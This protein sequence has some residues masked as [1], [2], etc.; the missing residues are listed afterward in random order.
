MRRLFII[1]DLH[2]GGSPDVRDTDGKITRTGYRICNAHRELVDFI[3]WAGTQ[4]NGPP[5]DL[6]LVINGDLVDFLADDDRDGPDLRACIWTENEDQAI[7]K[8][9]RIVERSW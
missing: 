4:G 2:L 7:R 9:D 8:L 6:E 5:E 3:A 1:S